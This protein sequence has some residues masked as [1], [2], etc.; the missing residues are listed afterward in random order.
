MT[1]HLVASSNADYANRI[2]AWLDAACEYAGEWRITLACVEAER[3]ETSWA[4]GV[5]DP[6]PNAAMLTYVREF[7]PFQPPLDHLQAGLF[8]SARE[9]FQDSDL[10]IFTDG[11][12]YLQRP[13]TEAEQAMLASWP[14]GTIGLSYNDGPADTLGTE[15]PR[16][17]PR[18]DLSDFDLTLPIYN[19]GVIV[20]RAGTYRRW[21]AS[22]A[23]IQPRMA[24]LFD[25]HA[26]Q[27]W[28]L[29]AALD[30]LS[31][32]VLP[33]TFHAHGHY[34]PAPGITLDRSRGRITANGE[35]VLFR[36]H[37]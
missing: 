20:A 9:R 25:H 7:L 27:Q 29:C 23:A 2:T 21:L 10:I 18:A 35:V 37:L 28:G 33:A 34:P 19:L 8:L 30:G 4:Y 12:A 6:Y 16:L 22:Y 15:A 36:H 1:I 14:Q 17:K 5:T 24:S 11:D 3:G 13:P 32:R 31:V 26:S